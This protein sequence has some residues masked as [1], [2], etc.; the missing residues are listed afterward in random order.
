MD[1]KKIMMPQTAALFGVSKNNPAHPANIILKKNSGPLSTRLF[2]VNPSGGDLNGVTVYKNV[3][4]I[5]SPPDTA[6]LVM[7]SEFIPAAMND[8][9][10]AGVS[11]AIIISGGFSEAG[12]PD[13]Q[14][15]VRRISIDNNFPV[16]G[17]NG[18][19]IISLPNLNTFFFPE[20]RFI[21]PLNGTLGLACQSGGVLVD[22]MIKLTHDGVG[23]SR[24]ISL[25]NKAVIDEIDAIRFFDS[26]ERTGVI[27]LYLEGFA[28]NRGR[29]FLE[30][31]HKTNKPVVI[32]KSGKSEASRDAISSH[33]AAIAGNYS[34]FSSVLKGTDAVEAATIPEFINA[35]ESLSCHKRVTIKNIAVITMSGGHG[36]ISTDTF[37]EA[38]FTVVRFP[39]ADAVQLKSLVSK[40]IQN[41]GSF[42]NPLDL[43]GSAVD[44]D[45]YIATKYALEKNYV[46]AVALLFLPFIPAISTAVPP[47]LAALQSEFK[48]PMVCYVPYLPKFGV[49]IE[50]FRFNGVPV[51]HTLN[52]CVEM[53]KAVRLQKTV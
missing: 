45:Y 31:I 41:I 11:G 24:V 46:D 35:C 36:V 52:G 34:F 27:G 40:N 30:A 10:D 3:R 25:G 26:D 23:V 20:E 4:D 51:S 33:T 19:G 16:I 5:E 48:K 37:Q 15:Q 44:D 13:L 2:C 39:E 12:R 49:F 29:D 38:G 42:I 6:I 21:T 9:I 8:C 18:L 14:E 17:P 22:L 28:E 47:K 7:K 50:S 1:I 32:L 43:T 53:M